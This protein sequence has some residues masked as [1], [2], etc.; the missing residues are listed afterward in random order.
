M[1]LVLVKPKCGIFPDMGASEIAESQFRKT[2]RRERES[3][4]WSQA[5]LATLLSGKGLTVYP[6]T[7]AKIEAGERAAKIDE[8]VAIADVFGVSVDVLLGHRVTQARDKDFLVSAMIDAAMRALW[9]IGSTEAALR[10]ALADLDSFKLRGYEKAVQTGCEQ[11]CDALIAAA[12]AIRKA[13]TPMHKIEER[14]LKSLIA[15]GG[16]RNEAR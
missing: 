9:Q 16:N 8:L 11:A 6:T 1:F 12:A 7:I 4:K 3:H 13:E 10:S 14:A 5:H 2:L 15:K